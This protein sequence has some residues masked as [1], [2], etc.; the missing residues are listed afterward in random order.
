M[1]VSSAYDIEASPAFV[2]TRQLQQYVTQLPS[3]PLAAR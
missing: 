3:R 2:P 1:G